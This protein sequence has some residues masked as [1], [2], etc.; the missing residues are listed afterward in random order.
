MHVTMLC[1]HPA[2]VSWFPPICVLYQYYAGG[3]G[4]DHGLVLADQS[5]LPLALA[6]SSTRRVL[7]MTCLHWVVGGWLGGSA[8]QAGGLRI[9]FPMG[10]LR[11]FIY[12][13]FPTALWP[14]DQLRLWQKWVTGI[15]PVGKGGWCVGPTTLPSSCADCL[16]ILGASTSWSPRGLP[17]VVEGQLYICG[18]A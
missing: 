12:F 7:P 17:R 8:L 16:R 10:S 13:F 5:P 9:L 11:C 4:G 2:V 6:R 15:P 3:H 14:W 1:A 18:L